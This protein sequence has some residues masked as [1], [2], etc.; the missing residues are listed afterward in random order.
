MLMPCRINRR[1]NKDTVVNGI[2]IKEGCL[3]A[4]PVYYLH[5][6]ED[7]WTDPERFNPERFGIATLTDK[8]THQCVHTYTNALYLLFKFHHIHY[9]MQA[10]FIPS[11]AGS[12]SLRSPLS[13]LVPSSLLG[14][15]LESALACGWHLWR[16]RWHSS[17]CSASSG[18]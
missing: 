9:S 8:H 14:V 17:K 3:V 4:I 16:P 18:L 7:F 5:F 11:A 15:G 6:K 2:P 1:C 13:T 12:A 10:N